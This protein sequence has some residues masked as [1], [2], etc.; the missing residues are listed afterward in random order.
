MIEFSLNDLSAVSLMFIP[1][2]HTS[3][4]S[5]TSN[6]N[7][8]LPVKCNVP[9]AITSTT[10]NCSS[11]IDIEVVGLYCSSNG[12]SCCSHIICGEHIVP[13]DLQHPVQTVVEVEN[14][15]IKEAVKVVRIVDGV[16]CCNIGF[17]P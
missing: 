4:M 10:N 6:D 3:V 5:A 14:G 12:R 11:E 15:V 13:G 9:L 17:I 8:M 2:T 16:D 1:Q 7:M